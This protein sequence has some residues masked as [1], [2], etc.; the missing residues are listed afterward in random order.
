MKEKEVVRGV[1][2][3][4][5]AAAEEECHCWRGKGALLERCS[6]MS[7]AVRQGIISFQVIRTDMRLYRSMRKTQ[8]AGS[9]DAGLDLSHDPETQREQAARRRPQIDTHSSALF[10]AWIIVTTSFRRATMWSD[11]FMRSLRTSGLYSSCSSSCCSPSFEWFTSVYVIDLGTMSIISRFT[12][13]KYELMSSSA[14]A[15]Q[16]SSALERS[17]RRRTDHLGL[18]RLPVTQR[19]LRADVDGLEGGREHPRRLSSTQPHAPPP[20]LPRPS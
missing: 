15:H 1:L 5:R 11:S 16:L 20:S 3:Y 6:S 19:R 17:V 14:G 13:L 9:H 10:N 7:I 18:H 4:G 2:S 12:M 8:C